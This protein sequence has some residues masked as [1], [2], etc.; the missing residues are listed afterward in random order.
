MPDDRSRV[1]P[2]FIAPGFEFV[3]LFDDVERD[4]HL[5]V[6]EHEQRIGVVQQDI[7]VENE[8]LDVA[9]VH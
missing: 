8:M 5:I 6:R 2:Q 7:G 3:E 9:V 1:A 4:D